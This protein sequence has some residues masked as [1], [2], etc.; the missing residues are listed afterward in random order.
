MHQL[1]VHMRVTAHS[2][3]GGE[4]V[5]HDASFDFTHQL[6]YPIEQVELAAGDW[7]SIECTYDNTTGSTVFW[8]DSSLSEMCFV[9]VGRYPATGGSFCAD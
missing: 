6:V 1:G 9:N 4:Q 8:G 2:A 7:L 5:I 3:G